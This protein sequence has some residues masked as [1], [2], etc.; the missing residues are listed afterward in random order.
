MIDDGVEI[1][2]DEIIIAPFI[3]MS[4]FPLVTFM[5]NDYATGLETPLGTVLTD[6]QHEHI[7]AGLYDYLAGED[8]VLN[9]RVIA[10]TTPN[11]LTVEKVGVSFGFG[12]Q[13]TET[14]QDIQIRIP[15][16]VT[17]S[18]VFGPDVEEDDV[19]T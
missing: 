11:D 5:G 9:D 4:K 6:A 2:I 1:I 18:S 3:G 13:T 10:S 17:L 15:K 12:F 14:V 7:L 19:V 16:E 8:G